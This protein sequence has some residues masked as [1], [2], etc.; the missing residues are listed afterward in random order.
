MMTPEPDILR[1]LELAVHHLRHAMLEA[2][3]QLLRD[4]LRS[5]LSRLDAI[6]AAFKSK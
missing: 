2:D 3:D 1:N 5:M 4:E 6:I